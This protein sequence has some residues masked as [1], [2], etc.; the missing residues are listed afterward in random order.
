MFVCGEYLFNEKSGKLYHAGCEISHPFFG[1]RE[2]Y[3]KLYTAYLMVEITEKFILPEQEDERM[4]RILINSLFSLEN[5][6]N[7]P[8]L[9]LAFFLV[10][11][12]D[13]AGHRPYAENCISCNTLGKS[14]YFVFES[15]GVMCADCAVK[16]GQEKRRISIESIAIIKQMLGQP[17]K[18]MREKIDIKIPDEL[19][20]ILVH[21]LETITNS[22][23]KSFQMINGVNLL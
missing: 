3:E 7:S 21:Y 22:K 16:I 14:Y 20:K 5:D 6:M 17:S 19:I 10:L 8:N 9:I 18:A 15:G 13:A 23:F 11:F 2:N 1:L 4:Y 12:C